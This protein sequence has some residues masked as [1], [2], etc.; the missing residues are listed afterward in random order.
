MKVSTQLIG[1]FMIVAAIGALIGIE[2]VLKADE[3]NGMAA[4]MYEREM[5]GLQHTAE[6]NILSLSAARSIRAAFLSSTDEQRTQHLQDVERLFENTK[7]S[8]N[9]SGLLFVRQAGKDL[10]AETQAALQTY[11]SSV[12][13]VARLLQSEPLSE[14]SPALTQLADVARP[15]GDKVDELMTRLVERKNANA[16]ELNN[17]TNQVYSSIR[18]L[19]IS[20]TVGGVL[21]GVAIGLLLARNLTRQLGGEPA[22]AA[23]IA[24]RIAQGDLTVAIHTQANDHTSLMAAMKTMRDSLVR[25]VGEVRQ[26]TDSI[27]TASSQIAAGNQELSSRT[28]QQA[29]SL[30]ETA[31]S[32]EELTSTVK[33]NGDNACQANQLALSASEVAIKGG[34]VVAQVVDTM[35]AINGSSRKIVD[36]IGVIDSIA[37]QT[38]ILALNAAVEAAR[39]GEQGRGFAVVAA[40]VRVLAQRSATAAKEIKELIDDSV[41]KVEQGSR[42]V[43]DAGKTMDEIVNSVRRVTDIMGEITA[44]SQEQTSGIEQINQAV[45]QMDQVTQQNAALVEE[46][47]AAADALQGQA[48]QLSQAVSAFKLEGDGAAGQGARLE[49]TP[50]LRS[51]GA[52]P[53]RKRVEV[54]AIKGSDGGWETF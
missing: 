6:A 2:G 25:I 54:A 26:G 8:L 37:F 42:Q 21:V 3:I 14:S 35:D 27:A 39:A 7:K 19:L 44:A 50:V 13:E 23:E 43:G 20:L 4:T 46:A 32:M 12:K 48:G 52:A 34:S 36:I 51:P 10:V 30:E 53:Q 28:E 11:E 45:A 40:E 16:D 24:A 17:E 9:E 18:V 41:S 5:V 22:H 33:Q 49:A 31:A 15:L 1:G 38:N 47:A 29:S